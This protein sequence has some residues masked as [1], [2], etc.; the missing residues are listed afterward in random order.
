MSNGSGFALIEL[1]VVIFIIVLL[2]GMLLPVIGIV[3]DKARGMVCSRTLANMQ[4][5]NVAYAGENEGSFVPALYCV[6][7]STFVDLWH[8]NAAYLDMVTGGRIDNGQYWAVPASYFCPLSRK[9]PS[10]LRMVTSYGYNSTKVYPYAVQTAVGARTSR[11]RLVST[12]AFMDALDWN[13]AMS[14]VAASFSGQWPEGL[15]KQNRVQPRHAKLANVVYY[16]GHVKSNG[17]N[18]LNRIDA[19]Y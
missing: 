9:D 11:G 16:D 3:R 17:L 13:I 4:L 18:E 8:T 14:G 7:N 19:W 12:V 5:A 10:N 6:A 15:Y 2:A 1:L